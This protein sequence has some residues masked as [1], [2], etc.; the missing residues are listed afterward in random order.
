[1]FFCFITDGELER[2]IRKLKTRL[3]PDRKKHQIKNRR[4][5]Q[6]QRLEA[7][8]IITLVF[9]NIYTDICI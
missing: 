6:M 1:M 5:Q 4:H 2:L 9:A 3:D 8:G 7:Q